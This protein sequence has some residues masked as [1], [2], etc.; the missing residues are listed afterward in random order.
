MVC[1]KKGNANSLHDV[2]EIS[3]Q[4]LTV[5]VVQRHNGFSGEIFDCI[6]GYIVIHISW[7]FLNVASFAEALSC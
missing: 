5:Q 3:I 4:N 7:I 6:G 1:L 2:Y